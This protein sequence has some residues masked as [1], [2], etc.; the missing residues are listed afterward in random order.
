MDKGIK[1]D[2]KVILIAFL[3]GISAYSI[4]KY[5]SLE[6]EKQGLTKSLKE[7]RI[8]LASLEEEKQNLLQTI[9][10]EEKINLSLKGNLK[11]GLRRINRLFWDN[12]KQKDELN[13]Q[14]SVLKA[15]NTAIREE[16]DKLK[17]ELSIISKERNDLIDR[18]SS[19]S[20][21]KK[22]LSELRHKRCK[23]KI[24]L[25]NRIEEVKDK[26]CMETIIEGNK[27]YLMKNGK[28]FSI[29]NVKIEVNPAQET[30]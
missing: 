15:E 21:L 29:G 2:Y 20:E 1:R 3:L 28:P 9:E 12:A 7:I 5:I 26:M 19:A 22:A 16:Q 23:K 8:Q 13:A 24:S 10:K 18:F 17:L 6:A 4:Y 30:K 11:A 14:I 27:G 25:V